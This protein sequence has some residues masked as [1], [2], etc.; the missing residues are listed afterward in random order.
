MSVVESAPSLRA[1]ANVAAELHRL[2]SDLYPICRSITGNGVRETLHRIQQILPLSIR[3]VPTGTRVFDWTVPREWNV[4]D[5]WVKTLD[6]QRVIDFLES[7]LHVV[8]YSI[9]VRRRAAL[10]E[11]KG[12][13]HTLPEHPTWIPY[14]TSYYAET[15]GFCITADRLRTL[16]DP[17]Y[18]VCIDSTL[19][20]GHL[21]YGECYLPGESPEEVLL[22]CHICHPSLCNDNL[23]GIS[24]AA[25]LG[26][27]LTSASRR[28]FSYRLLFVPGT[29]GSI[30]WLATNQDKLS[31]IRHGLVLSGLGGP[32]GL[33]YKRSRQGVATVDRAAAHV[34]KHWS[35]DSDIREFVPYG[36]D[37]R[38]YCSP[39]INLAVGCLSRTPY[40][41]YPEYHTS[42]DD[43]SFVTP[44]RLEDSYHACQSILKVLE[45]D[46]TYENLN[47]M[48]EPQLGRRGLYNAMGGAAES[49][50]REI[51]LLW[52]LNLSDGCHSL[53]DIAE[54]SRQPFDSVR[55]AALALEQRGLLRRVHS[56]IADDIERLERTRGNS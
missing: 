27:W 31:A 35:G 46:V 14:K 11:L 12:H 52:V 54:R 3:E 18:E 29:I 2:M 30:T 8:S 24:V 50:S 51:V 4:R 16:T 17:E 19:E 13:L 45:H 53:L 28:R 32:G 25:L 10:S 37:E 48:C 34:L 56:G 49:R 5:A 42:A 41:E 21:T 9:P 23:S 36:Y 6:G 55:S 39:G 43:L 20:D 44:E 1:D 38:Q 33:V 7:N 22:S 47:P 40:G 26:R 15:W